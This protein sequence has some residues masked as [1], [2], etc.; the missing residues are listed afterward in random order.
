MKK[1]QVP[2][3]GGIRKM[4]IPDTTAVGTTIAELG[5]NTV[6]LA[7]LAALIAAATPP[8]NTGGGNIGTG[9]EATLTPGPGLSGG[10]VLIGNVPIRLTIPSALITE[11]GVDGDPGMQGVQGLRGI[12]GAP[13]IA[14]FAEDGA[15]GDSG[16][17][18]L[19]GAAGVA[20]AAGASGAAGA[21]GPPG[22][23]LVYA[24]TTIPV[25]NT[26]SNTS[27]ETFFA[28]TYT[29]PAGSLAAGMVIRL[30]L[31]GVYSTGIVAPSL[32]LR[33]Y[34]G[35]TVMIASGTLTTVAGVTND[36]WSAE[37]LFTVQTIGSLGTI[38]A[39]GLSEFSTAS[40][41]VLFIN[42]DNAAPVT[43]NTTIAETVQASVQWGGTVNASDTITLREMTVEVM[44][45][46]GIP[47]VTPAPMVFPMFFAE[48]G[49]EGMMGFPGP[50]GIAGSGGANPFNVTPDTHGSGV[51][52]FAANDYFE[53]AAL[54]TGGTRFTGAVAWTQI[55]FS[56]SGASNTPATAA[57]VEGALQFKSAL[58]PG[59]GLSGRAVSMITQPL[60][61]G[62]AWRYRAKI[63]MYTTGSSNLGG[64]AAYESSS[65]KLLGWGPL[66]NP[67]NVY[68]A[69]AGAFT[70][71]A[72][73]FQD[74]GN[75]IAGSDLSLEPHVPAVFEIQPRWYE[76]ERLSGSLFLRLST[77]GLDGTFWPY[78]TAPISSYFTTAP[79][80]IGLYVDAVG[81]SVP[82]TLLTVDTFLREA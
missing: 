30:K 65:G 12:Q 28:S 6:T 51:P 22:T 16:A 43:V 75:A 5:S 11:D 1:T 72:V 70:S 31:F 35:S 59:G 62:S 63:G 50:Q 49:E 66:V 3:V 54:D 47:S 57:L 8:V 39:Q 2:S 27:A 53:E 14:M 19:P 44:S 76:L 61:G 38:E 26:V 24:N 25:G 18:G 55:N 56:P 58:G 21:A 15:D 7:Q 73:F 34:F 81:S 74:V 9:N 10:G 46:A 13:G 52:A 48:D 79:D 67:T 23:T 60:P 42:M 29:I 82:L 33:V 68:I 71:T 37:G 69:F 32:I 36:G 78:L 17:P 40:T 20:G 45:I 64:L 41:A 77:S 80:S 4:L